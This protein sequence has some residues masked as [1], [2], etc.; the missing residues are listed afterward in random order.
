MKIIIP[1]LLLPPIS[2]FIDALKADEW[3]IEINET[4]QSK[5]SEID[6]I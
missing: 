5:H 6:I 2:F 3:L 1:S 4:L